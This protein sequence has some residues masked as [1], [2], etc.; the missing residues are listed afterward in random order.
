MPIEAGTRI[1]GFQIEGLLG[2]GGMA[3]VYRAIQIRLQRPVALKIL[4]PALAAD[5]QFV[6][7]FQLEGV[8][9]ARLEHLNIVPVYEA[10]EDA[11]HVFLAMKLVEG[12]TLRDL[13][14]TRG[15]LPPDEAV[16]ILADVARALD[17]AHRAG[18]V[19]RDVKPANIL[20][21]RDGHVYLSDFGLT[22]VV[23]QTSITSTGQWMG[24]PEYM[25]PEQARGEPVDH[26]ADL[27]SFTCVAF[28]CVT[29]QPPFLGQDPV[30]LIVAH[31]THDIPPATAL[32]LSLPPG[33]DAVFHRGLAKSPA[34]RYAS[35]LDLIEALQAA[36]EER[37]LTAVGDPADGAR[38]F[39]PV[40][41]PDPAA[42]AP[43]AAPVSVPSPVTATQ[44][45]VCLARLE[46]G[47]RHC[48][49]CG[50]RIAWCGRCS[51][52]VVFG[53]R[54]CQHCGSPNVS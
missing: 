25:P 49:S 13:L 30:A 37:R 53:D 50:S 10:G 15:A 5:E 47:Y 12:Q 43:A 28:E 3:S 1:G 11:G 32:N 16:R 4:A 42:A 51:G 40:I 46:Y 27:Y 48:G 41:G 29:G 34:D 36:L 54:F 45:P 44:C 2:K 7:R 8:N 31:A 38:R 33:V 9:A 24:T 20:I 14:T 39:E 26:R 23:G 21:T 19:H 35:A 6:Q 18:F 22:K 52:A 17:Y